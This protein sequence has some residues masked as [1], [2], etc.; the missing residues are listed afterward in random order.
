MLAMATP[1]T[2]PEINATARAEPI[3]EATTNPRA[4]DGRDDAA[5]GR[6]PAQAALFV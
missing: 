6:A 4:D 1:P 5:S 2:T 3:D